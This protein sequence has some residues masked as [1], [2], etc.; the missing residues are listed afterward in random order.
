MS[1][2]TNKPSEID[3]KLQAELIAEDQK[4]KFRSQV[5]V[6]TEKCWEKCMDK[7]GNRLEKKT[8]TCFVNCVNRFVD[9]SLFIVKRFSERLG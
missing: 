2:G 6:L 9:T 8:E 5:L 3:P 4:S 1:F 7:P